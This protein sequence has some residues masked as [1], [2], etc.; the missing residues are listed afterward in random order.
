MRHILLG[1]LAVS[2]SFA[3]LAAEATLQFADI[4]RVSVWRPGGGRLIYIK[5][6]KDQW[7]KI[8]LLEPCMDL[9]PGKTPTFITLTDTQ[10]QRYSAVV[11]ERHQCSVTG[12][13]K[14]KGEPPRAPAKKTELKK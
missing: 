11:I 9:Y 3:A 8:E 12:L 2:A 14:L 5:D 13:S 6:L 7:F 1:V 4:G 10:G